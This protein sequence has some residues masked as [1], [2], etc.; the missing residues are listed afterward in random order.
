MASGATRSM[1]PS[2]VP[3]TSFE[4]IGEKLAGIPLGG[5]W[6]NW[7]LAM[8]VAVALTGVLVGSLGYL[9]LE[10]TAIWGNNIPVTWA[11]DIVSYDWWIG[12]AC[13]GL[14]VSGMFLLLEVEWRSA[15][16]RLSETMALLAAAAAAVYPIIHLGRPW[17][18]FWNLPYPN[19]YALWPQFRSPLVWDAFDILS[20]LGIAAGLWFVGLLPDLA[21]LR[22]RAWT[23]ARADR[24]GRGLLAAQ[25]YGLAALGWRGSVVHWHRWVQAYRT[26][27]LLGV[28][29][30]VTL[31]VGASV[32]FAGTLEPGWHDTLL[33][34][35][36]L[37]GAVFAGV[38]ILSVLTVVLRTAFHLESLITTR[39][40][41][42]LAWLLFGLCCANIYCEAATAFSVA[43][44]GDSFEHAAQLRRIAGPVAWSFWMLVAGGLLPPLLFLLPRLR[45]S[46]RML[47]WAGGAAAAGIWGDHYALIVGSLQHDFLPSAAHLSRIT[48][49]EWSIFAGSAGLFLL[50]LLLFLR[51][52]PIVSMTESRSATTHTGAGSK[53]T[54]TGPDSS[55]PLWGI[56]AEFGSEREMAGATRA[57]RGLDNLR[58]DAFSPVPSAQT[59]SA[60][61]LDSHKI[62]RFAAGGFIIGSASVFGMCSYATAYDYVFN[63]GGR[64]NFSWPSYVVPSV[65]GGCLLAGM[66]VVGAMLILNRLPRLNHPAFNIP[67]IERASADR[68]FVAAH[69]RD[70]DL[71]P[72]QAIRTLQ[73]FTSFPIHRVPR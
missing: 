21:S 4:S 57:L 28:V 73:S 62:Q 24:E 20:F 3:V 47:A 39:H 70:G 13:G 1:S 41:E 22:D 55:A 37:A 30:V 35:T 64:P 43:V 69:A 2:M 14:L 27:A 65:A 16:N 60:L 45:V 61:G 10:G 6:R 9:F 40:I 17:F 52:L 11:L 50:L 56:A 67:G 29:V 36:Y 44:N 23:G 26:L 63:I 18:F 42:R 38:G 48:F 33:P 31:Q 51:F 72:E 12:I 66:A 53:P 25:L 32:M 19:T 5:G 58:V 49:F 15:L 34:V 54:R 8:A 59:A 46:P 68:F 71:D 7:W